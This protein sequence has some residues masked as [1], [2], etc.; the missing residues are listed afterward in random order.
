MELHTF[1]SLNENFLN[2]YKGSMDK[3]D[4]AIVYFNPHTV[5]QKR[6]KPVSDDQVKSSFGNSRLLVFTDS[7]K[8]CR[9]LVEMNPRNTVLLM[10]SS[11]TFDGMNLDE[12]AQTIIHKS[13]SEV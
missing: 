6:L 7:K 8:L 13:F 3:A 10:M 2:E 11:G 9:H 12:L 1:S 5:E 4:E